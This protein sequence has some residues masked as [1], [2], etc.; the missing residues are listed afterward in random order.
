MHASII[1]ITLL[2]KKEGR[3]IINILNIHNKQ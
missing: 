2:R 3:K 1:G